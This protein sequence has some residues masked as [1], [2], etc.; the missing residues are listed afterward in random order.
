MMIIVI[1][2]ILIT[3]VFLGTGIFLIFAGRW[4]EKI[5]G[6]ATE[7]LPL[8][9]RLGVWQLRTMGLFHIILS[10]LVLVTIAIPGV[11]PYLPFY[12]ALIPLLVYF[13]LIWVILVLSLKSK[14]E[15]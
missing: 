8:I 7:Q 6:S 4:I 11:G 9:S 13:L 5:T 15:Q 10:V 12:I 1:F 3:I 2:T 14:R